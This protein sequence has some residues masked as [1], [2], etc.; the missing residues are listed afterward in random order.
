ML[1]R[2]FLQVKAEKLR[3]REM[4]RALEEDKKR[5]A[6]EK[7]ARR[8]E[9]EKR[10]DENARKNEVVQQVKMV[11]NS[12]FYPYLLEWSFGKLL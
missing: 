2:G 1:P 5:E 11:H 12:L 7:R 9:N 4:A 8:E 6:A 10:R 3:V